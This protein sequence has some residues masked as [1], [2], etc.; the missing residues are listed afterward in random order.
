MK[1]YATMTSER[2]KPVSKSGN[3]YLQIDILD[4]D[5]QS[6]F[7]LCLKKSYYN[8]NGQNYTLTIN[9]YQAQYIDIKNP[10]IALNSP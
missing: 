8:I 7:T 6:L 4:E 9:N 5:R 3:E 10:L 1:L 2:G